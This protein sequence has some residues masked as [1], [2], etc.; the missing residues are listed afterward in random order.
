MAKAKKKV[1]GLIE[2]VKI[3]GE[4][5]I[6]TYALFDTGARLTSIDIR[7]ASKAKLGPVVKTTRIKNPSFK[8]IIRRPVVMAKIK[9]KGKVFEGYAN[10]QDR[11]HMTFPVIIGRNIIAGSFLVDAKKNEK[12]FEKIQKGCD[13]GQSYL[14]DFTKSK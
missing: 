8:T 7:L 1:V 13:T 4:K 2:K 12:L 11:S 9:I 14:H 3:M 10:L 6:E 5:E